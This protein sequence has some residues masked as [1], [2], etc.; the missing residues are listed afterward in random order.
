M[1]NNIVKW[2]ADIREFDFQGADK[3]EMGIWP[4]PIKVMMGLILTLS[5]S[6]LAYQFAVS[7]AQKV[8]GSEMKKERESL[9]ELQM[10]AASA[11]SIGEY[12]RQMIQVQSMLN[13][14]VSRLPTQIEIPGL[15]DDMNKSA[16]ESGLDIE[17]LELMDEIVTQF[18]VELPISVVVKGAYQDILTFISHVSNLDRIVVVKEVR[19]IKESEN[20]IQAIIVAKTFRYVEAVDEK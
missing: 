9:V 2:I 6:A 10:K 18:Y 8:N 3:S 17:S 7:P 15:L 19:A 11:A 13:R 14:L 16:L 1:R 12:K 4:G 5:I 20:T